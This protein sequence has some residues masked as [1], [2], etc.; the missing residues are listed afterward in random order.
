M[1][2]ITEDSKNRSPYW[3]ACFTA[4][5]GNDR[6]QLK[7]STATRDRKLAQRIADELE[8]AAQGRRT[9][10]SVQT[11]LAGVADLRAQRAARHSFDAVL[12]KTTGAGLDSKTAR[13]Y[14]TE[15]LER[16]EG[17]MAKTTLSKYEWTAKQLFASL[18]GKADGDMAALRQDDVARF[19][20]SEAKRVS[21]STA[22]QA[23][24][25]VRVFFAAAECDGVVPRNVARLVR[26]G[27]DGSAGHARRPFTLPELKRVLAKCDDEWRSLVLF[28]LYTGARL[29]DL[30]AMTWQ[31]VDLQSR[32]L[33]YV[34]R[35]TKRPVDLPIA[36]PLAAHIESMSAGDDPKAPLHPRAFAIL[37]KQ[38]R[39]GTL[40]NQFAE[41]LADAGLRTA[42]DHKAQ[43]DGPGRG[44][45]RA[46]SDVSFHAI[47][48]TAVSLLKNAGVSD[49]VARDIVGHESEAVS[50]LYTHIEDAAKRRALAKLPDLTAADE[51]TRKKG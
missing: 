48:H 38:E 16:N 2:S 42:P 47:R 19:R 50:R 34:S 25:L 12:R 21:K 36:G 8:E 45:K 24:K 22:N 49:A 35:K 46:A 33:N 9:Q 37:K 20:N 6:R 51:R 4:F 15:W 27:R 44:G 17:T 43:A 30:A 31:A 18:G 23:L 41:I 29:G 39:V 26:L 28:G 14:I 7:K 40:S 32:T 10:E 3:I 11:F 13:G 1:S 5:V